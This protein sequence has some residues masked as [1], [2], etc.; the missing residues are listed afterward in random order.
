MVAILHL[1]VLKR[2]SRAAKLSMNHLLQAVKSLY[3]R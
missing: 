2:V 1:M 3:V